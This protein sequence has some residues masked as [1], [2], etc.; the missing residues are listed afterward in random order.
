MLGLMVFTVSA[1]PGRPRPE[2]LNDEEFVRMQ[3][4]DMAAWLQLDEESNGVFV[5]TYSAFRLEINALVS[6][7]RPEGKRAESE[8]EIDKTLQ[9]NFEVSE[10][11]L[12]IRKRY[13]SIFKGFLKPSQIQQMYR[14]EN[15]AGRRM[16][17]GPGNPEMPG[18]PSRHDNGQR[19]M[20][21]PPQFQE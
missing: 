9:Q 15:E 3:A 21:P 20:G 12:E 17:E 6:K 13:Y 11:I 1:Q 7:T 4:R 5:D 16:H 18:H 19:P 14:H 2:D 10:K 8:D